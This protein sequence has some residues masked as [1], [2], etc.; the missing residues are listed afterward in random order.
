MN[1][2]L[3]ERLMTVLRGGVAD[4]VPWTIYEWLLPKTQA[5]RHMQQQGLTL[6]GSVSLCRQRQSDVVIESR[7]VRR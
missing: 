5:A 3:R 4:R 6:I 7:E 1:I 2:N